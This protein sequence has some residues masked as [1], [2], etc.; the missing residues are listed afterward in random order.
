MMKA[1]NSSYVARKGSN[2]TLTCRGY[3]PWQNIVRFG[4]DSMIFPDVGWTFNG[5][6]ITEED[7]NK[8]ATEKFQPIRGRNLF[9]F[10]LHIAN[11]SEKDVGKYACVASVSNTPKADVDEDFIELSLY[12]KGEFHL[13]L[14]LLYKFPLIR[15]NSS[16][17]GTCL[18]PVFSV[19]IF[20]SE[21]KIAKK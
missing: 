16:T 4:H 1:V 11:V 18:K 3:M 8:K 15:K 2:V 12:K 13:L 21:L 9:H 19:S 6:P 14:L 7:T 17:D 5:H 10:P 20:F